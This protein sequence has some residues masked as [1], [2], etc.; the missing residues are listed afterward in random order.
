VKINERQKKMA[1]RT[2]A[3]LLCAVAA[4]ASAQSGGKG[5]EQADAGGLG[6]SIESEMLTYRALQS[7]S[8][9]IA[10]DVAAYV[11]GTAATFTNSP[12]GQVCNVQAHG[13]HPPGIIL[14]SFDRSVF[15]GFAFWRAEMEVMRE[16]QSR[17]HPYCSGSV[18]LATESR[19]SE[20][21]NSAT[22]AVA[23]AAK[24][25]LNLTPY[26]TALQLSQSLLGMF[27]TVK[28]AAPVMGTIQDQAFIDGVGRQLRALGV[29]VVAPSTYAPSSLAPIEAARSP[30]LSGIN[31]LLE[32][33]TCLEDRDAGPGL[34]AAD[35]DRVKEIVLEIDAYLSVFR[36]T[37]VNQGSSGNSGAAAEQGKSSQKEKE[38]PAASAQAATAPVVSD[39]APLMAMLAGDDL[40]RKLGVD[41]ATGVL[42]VSSPWRHVL[43]VKAL[44][45][46]GTVGGSSNIFG[47]KSRYSGGSVGTYALFSLDGTMECSGNVY[48]FGGSVAAETFE[49]DLKAYQP[50]PHSQLLFQRGSC[51]SGDSSQDQAPK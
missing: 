17:A 8:E 36:G 39:V 1:A 26:G 34:S 14:S 20:Q 13:S 24:S 32:A 10:C 3:V 42:P 16:I 47:S 9:A 4:T 12:Q 21:K 48:E 23:S 6:F 31:R 51:S 22:A 33:R 41:P 2:V 50:D 37:P 18:V 25:A 7:N 38:S 35:K 49:K 40:A 30:F 43:L 46:G 44:E 11:S 15:D 29:P 28:T 19:G 45:S 5:G 27:A